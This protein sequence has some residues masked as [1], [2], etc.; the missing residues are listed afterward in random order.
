MSCEECENIQNIAFNKNIDEN[1]PIVYIR[2]GNAN[3]AV[4][5]CE[6]HA[7]ETCDKIRGEE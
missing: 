2:V 3:V 5:A 4:V 1:I 6:K 7:K